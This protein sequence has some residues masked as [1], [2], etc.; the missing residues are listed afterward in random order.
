MG[1]LGRW[2]FRL[3]RSRS[4]LDGDYRARKAT[5]CNDRALNG[6]PGACLY[7]SAFGDM[8]REKKGSNI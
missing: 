2:D 6:A 7:T 3:E 1:L 8:E 5:V 4:R